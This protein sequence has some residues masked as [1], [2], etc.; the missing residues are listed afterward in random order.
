MRCAD[1]VDGTSMKKILYVEMQTTDNHACLSVCVIVWACCMC[2]CVYTQCQLAHLS[3]RHWILF[4]PL[5]LKHAKIFGCR[6]QKSLDGTNLTLL[7][8]RR[9]FKLETEE[10]YTTQ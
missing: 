8:V 1:G 2:R 10:K 7:S 4:K 5:L 6:H 3:T 9:N